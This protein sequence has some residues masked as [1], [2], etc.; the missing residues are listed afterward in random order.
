MGAVGAWPSGLYFARVTTPGRGPGTRR[1]SCGPKRLGAHR[2]AV[3]LPTNTWQAY[4]FREDDGDG[5]GDSWYADGPRRVDLDAAVPRRRRAAAL[6]RLRPRLHPLAHRSTGT[7]APTSSP[8]TTSTG[9][10]AGDELA[11]A[12][13]LIVFPGHE[14]YV[15]DARIRPRSQRYRDLGG[16]LAFLSANDFFYQVVKRR[17]I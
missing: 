17:A 3:V 16:N 10:R 15:T 11:R 14:E 9:S 2:V 6:P 1:S 8:T 12:Y 4:N 7:A 5:V 13:D